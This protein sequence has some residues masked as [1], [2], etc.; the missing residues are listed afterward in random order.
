MMTKSFR[1]LPLVWILLF[2][3]R[4]WGQ[5]SPSIPTKYAPPPAPSG[6]PIDQQMDADQVNGHANQ[7]TE[8]S[9]RRKMR[10]DET[11]VK[12]ERGETASDMANDANPNQVSGERMKLQVD[13]PG[14]GTTPPAA[15]PGTRKGVP[16]TNLGEDT[17]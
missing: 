13:Q 17:D 16:H 7:A 14:R 2:S 12:M 1:F 8:K 6:N 3:L 11:S 5:N 10:N 9:A 15:A 4:G